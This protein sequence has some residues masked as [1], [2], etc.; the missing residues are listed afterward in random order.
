MQDTQA[1]AE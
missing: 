1:T